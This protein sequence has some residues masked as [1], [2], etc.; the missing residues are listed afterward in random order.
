MLDAA[1]VALGCAPWRDDIDIAGVILNLVSNARHVALIAPVFERLK[2]PV[3]GAWLRDE[4]IVLPERHLSLVQ[5]L[6][7]AVIDN[8]LDRL[9]DVDDAAEY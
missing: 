5:A 4:R 7:I 9:A 2:L 3:F 1:A 6:E 8:N